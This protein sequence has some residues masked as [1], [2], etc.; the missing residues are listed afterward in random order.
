MM[1][2]VATIAAILLASVTS[3]ALAGTATLTDKGIAI[4]GGAVGKFNLSYPALTAGGKPSSTVVKDNTV[5]LTYDNG[6]KLHAVLGKNGELACEL[7]T[8]ASDAKKLRMDIA[9]PESIKNTAQ[10]TIDGTGPK[11]FPATVGADA[12]LFKADAKVFTLS[13]GKD[14]KEGFTITMP[15]GFMQLQDNRFWKGKD[16]GWFTAMDLPG[17]AADGKVYLNFKITG[18]GEKSAPA[19]T[20][21]AAPKAAPTGLLNVKLTDKAIVVSNGTAGELNLSLPKLDIAGKLVGSTEATLAADGHSLDL[22]YPGGATGHVTLAG[23]ELNVS[24]K[25]LPKGATTFRV[26]TLIPINYSGGGT[27]AVGG[28]FPAEFPKDKPAKPFLYQGNANKII[29]VHPTG[30]A[31]TM[32]IPPYSFQQLQDNREWNWST[33]AWFMNS[34]LAPDGA[35]AA[36]AIKFE[37]G[38]PNAPQ[39]PMVDR[40]GQW[41]KADFPGKVKSEDELKQD[42]AADKE[43]LA[44]LK[45]PATDACGGLAGSGEKLGLKKTGYFHLAN[46]KRP[47]PAGGS[48]DLLVTPEGNAFFQLGVCAISPCDDYTTVAGRESIYEWLPGRD[49]ATLSARREGNNGV[50]SFYL[51]NTI[52]KYGEPYSLDTHFGRWID[53]LRAWGFNSAG[54]FNAIP[55]VIKEKQFPYVNFIPIP[56]PK[57]GSVNGVWDPFAPD[58]AAKFDAAYAKDVAP[59]AEDPLL[60]GYFICNEPLI[61]DVPKT[62][63]TLKASQCPSKAKLVALLQEKYKTIEA[64]NAAWD[65]KL[66]SFED[67][68]EQALVVTTRAAADDM[69]EFFKLFLET[70]YSLVNTAFRKHDANHLLIGDR[71][72]PGTAN[73]EVLVKTAAKYLDVVSINYYTYGIDKNFLD[74]I[75]TWAGKPLLFSEW[76]FAV[77]DQGLRGGSK[78]NT[79]AE[80]GLAYRNYIEQSAALGYV[81]GAQWFIALD[82]AATGRFFEGFNGEAANT[83]LVNVADRPYKEFLTEAMKSNYTLYDVILGNRAPYAFDDPRFSAK[84]AGAAKTVSISRMVNKFVL[85]GSRSEWPSVPPY[86]IGAEGLAQGRD[87]NGF[88]AT[89]RLA[90]D[91]TNLYLFVEVTDA[92]PMKNDQRPE[93]IWNGDAVELFIGHEDITVGG[94]L[95]F[96]DRQVLV[97]GAKTS[98]AGIYF[99]N[100]PK[101]YPAQTIVVPNLD[102]KGYTIEA[103]IPF[104]AL[105]FVP[106]DN[107]EILFDIGVDDSDTGTG[108]T[109]QI[110]FNG[111]A[112]NSK[113]RGAWGRATFVK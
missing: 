63:P 73:S 57:L 64:F 6:T 76:Y 46:I 83:G 101:Q 30:A 14:G 109:R 86:R 47:G 75:H 11:E 5:D 62:V 43:W 74:R 44:S 2:P 112:R 52:R 25:D 56:A 71:W 77:P 99:S 66:A 95:K 16:F 50:V 98:E 19:A 28:G 92:T 81:V 110:V 87:A 70:R 84:R 61:E 107:Q 55:P 17:A 96:S 31:L 1:R 90:Y 106:K 108:R 79:Q 23:K 113:D 69:G 58:L 51:A 10:W 94:S 4:D 41:V 48:T 45:P 80:R 39:P 38:D 60:I 49:N 18:V 89:F 20:P 21:K 13:G 103:A 9:L 29:L 53:R 88:E 104:E 36:L 8:V 105:G 100:A 42:V 67:A 72:M 54:A 102:G 85:D 33:F 27:Y 59:K 91:N 12:F 26:E 22:K 34:P 32:T 97:R 82:Q 3:A 65:A 37:E 68:G 93:G 15:F 78:V 7:T 24:F 35:N 40:F 111:N